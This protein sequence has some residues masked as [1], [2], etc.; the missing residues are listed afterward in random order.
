[1]KIEHKRILWRF[2]LFALFGLLMEVFFG[3]TGSLIKGNWHTLR[4]GSSPWMMIDYGLLGVVLMPLAQPMMRRGIP[5]IGRAVVYMAGIF[6]VE[7]VSGYVF[8]VVGIEVWDYSHL[9]LNLGGYITLTYAPFWYVL[10]LFVE[11]IYRRLDAMATVV[12]RGLCA[13]DVLAL[14][15]PEEKRP[16]A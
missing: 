4:G 2:L 12:A 7:L 15:P 13:D 8:D 5:L 11:A 6:L 9:P 3:A 14:A 16:V 1:M 10:G